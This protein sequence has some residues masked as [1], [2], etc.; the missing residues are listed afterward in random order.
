MHD[1]YTNCTE[2]LK[3]F[4]AP[5]A[6]HL[7]AIHREGESALYIGISRASIYEISQTNKIRSL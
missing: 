3:L 6:R 7:L 5:L 1:Y 4:D 2:S